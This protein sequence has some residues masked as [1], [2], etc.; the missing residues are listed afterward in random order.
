MTANFSL[1]IHRTKLGWKAKLISWGAQMPGDGSG[2]KPETLS[3]SEANSDNLDRTLSEMAFGASEW[4]KENVPPLPP[5]PPEPVEEAPTAE[6]ET[7]T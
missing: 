2:P 6:A 3:V 7:P 1:H 4:C 5:A